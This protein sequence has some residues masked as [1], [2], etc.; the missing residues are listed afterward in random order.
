MNWGTQGEVEGRNFV[1]FRFQLPGTKHFCAGIFQTIWLLLK[2][3]FD[4]IWKRY[5]VITLVCTIKNDSCLGH[6]V[7]FFRFLPFSSFFRSFLSFFIKTTLY[8]CRK[9]HL[10]IRWEELTRVTVKTFQALVGAYFLLCT[11]SLHFRTSTFSSQ[12][13]RWEEK[14]FSITIF[15]PVFF[16]ACPKPGLLWFGAKGFL[17]RARYRTIVEQLTKE[18]ESER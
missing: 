3:C 13:C 2:S 8:D 17:I 18:G 14:F 7:F 12:A 16:R 15:T 5:K 4:W 11:A 9:H 10:Q 1:L 6:W